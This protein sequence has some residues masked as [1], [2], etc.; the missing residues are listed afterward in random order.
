VP[1][2]PPP[3]SAGDESNQ[4]QPGADTGAAPPPPSAARKPAVAALAAPAAA[5]SHAKP[6]APAAKHEG[7]FAVQLGA[8]R[9]GSAAAKTRWEH[10]QKEYPQ[11]L[12][13]LSSKVV[14][15][16]TS[17]GTLYRLQAVGVSEGHARKICKDLKAKSQ[18]CVIVRVEHT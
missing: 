10:L 7:E 12:A 17:G 6:S 5:A 4:A 16:K 8:F 11:L 15:K 2:V 13:G 18:P 1:G 14:P 3:S 9:S